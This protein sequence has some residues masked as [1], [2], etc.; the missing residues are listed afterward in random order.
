MGEEHDPSKGLHDYS[1]RGLA[2]EAIQALRSHDSMDTLRFENMARQH[3][4]VKQLI[5]DLRKDMVTGFKSYDG[6]F[7]SLAITVIATLT[8][9][10]GAL[11][12]QVLFHH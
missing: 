3:E 12:Y 11:V 6:K 10:V 7:W 9:V 8:T 2:A 4:E 1:A 5:T